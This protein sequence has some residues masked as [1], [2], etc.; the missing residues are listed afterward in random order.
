MNGSVNCGAR[1]R[2]SKP[3]EV[4]FDWGGWKVTRKRRPVTAAM[5]QEGNLQKNHIYFSTLYKQPPFFLFMPPALTGQYHL[6]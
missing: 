2:K 3:W 1:T 6:R 5:T 4:N